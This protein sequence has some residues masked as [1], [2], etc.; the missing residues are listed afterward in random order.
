MLLSACSLGGKDVVD[1]NIEMDLQDGEEIETVTEPL[2]T[3]VKLEYRILRVSDGE[4]AFS[5]EVPEKW[6]AE[7]R[8]AGNRQLTVE[9]MRDFLATN[10]YADMRTNPELYSNYSQPT[11]I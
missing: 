4:I 9:E 3:S 7:T 10:H 11:I 6:L 8:H 1:E 5:F 2:T